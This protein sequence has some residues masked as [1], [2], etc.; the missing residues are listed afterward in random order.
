M[1]RKYTNDSKPLLNFSLPTLLTVVFTVLAI[2]FAYLGFS[3]AGDSRVA[4]ALVSAFLF[5]S[6]ACFAGQFAVGIRTRQRWQRILAFISL[7]LGV[8]T[9]IM[10]IMF[11]QV[12]TEVKMPF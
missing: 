7:F 12:L 8:F 11:Y 9:V 4:P 1:T 3:K 5:I 2:V 10:A 6:G